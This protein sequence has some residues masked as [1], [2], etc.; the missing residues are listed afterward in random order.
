MPR[1]VPEGFHTVT[2]ALTIRGCAEAISLY[3]KAFGARELTR[4]PDPSG[5]LIWHATIQIGDSIIMLNDEFPQMGGRATPSS[6]WL[7]LEGVDAAFDRAVSAGLKIEQPLA[8][9]FWGDRFGGLIDRFGIR[10]SLAQHIKDLTPE[11]MKKA[12]DEA[13]RAWSKGK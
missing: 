13:A 8:D 1:A 5:K 4:A 9:M 3:Q 12:Q 7:Y 10:W 2:P 6:L 11:E